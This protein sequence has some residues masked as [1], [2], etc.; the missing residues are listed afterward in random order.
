[1][2]YDD[3]VAASSFRMCVDAEQYF[4]IV[5]ALRTNNR[6][7]FRPLLLHPIPGGSRTLNAR[8]L[9]ALILAPN[10]LA[11]SAAHAADGNGWS[12]T[13]YGGPASYSRASDIFNGR[14]RLNGA[15]FGLAVDK[16]L[17]DLGS[18]ISI[19]AE[20]QVTEYAITHTYTTVAL[21][22]GLRF[23]RFPWN[24][25]SLAIY[26]GPSYAP[27]SPEITDHQYG[28]SFRM[29][30]FLNY[31]SVEFAVAIPGHERHW[32]AVM[33]IYHRSGAWGVYSDNVDEGSMI[34][35]GLR[36]KF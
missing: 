10:L 24:N 8:W 35:F 29:V 5:T 22:L 16:R 4:A 15:M 19:G 30:K 31:I 28:P 23:D 13:L 6:A 34:G 1:M 9:R 17:I 11:A 2:Q 36:A 32:D 26:S 7:Y 25:T 3:H 27:N 14:G 12:A 33:R 18:G 21:G 20:G